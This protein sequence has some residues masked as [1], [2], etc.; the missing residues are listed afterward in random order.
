MKAKLTIAVDDPLVVSEYGLSPETVLTPDEPFFLDGPVAERV[1]VVDRDPVSGQIKPVR[2]VQEQQTY[3]VPDD[4]SQPESVAASVFG[5]VLETLELLEGADILGH[6]VKWSFDSPQLLLVPRAGT[7]DNAFYDRYSGSMQFFS[8]DGP[9]R[10]R[11]NTA[12]SRDIVTHETGHAILDGLLPAL[13]DAAT[14]QSLAL[15]EAIGDLTAIVMALQSRRIRDWLLQ[16]NGGVLEGNTPVSQLAN[17]FGWATFATKRP[18]RNANNQCTV[19]SA[20]T[21]PHDLCEVL[22][23][24]FWKAIVKLHQSAIDRA[25]ASTEASGEEALGRALGISSRRIARILFRALDYVPPAEATFA[26]YARAVLWSDGIV[27]PDDSTGYRKTLRDEFVERGI[28]GSQDEL[29]A[30]PDADEVRA[31]LNNLVESEWYAFGF[32]ERNR[33]LLRIPPRTPFRLFP[34]RDVLRRY[35][36]GGDSHSTKREV[37]FQ[38]TWQKNEENVGIPGVPP[39]RAVFQGTTLVLGGESDRRG[40]VPVLSCLTTD[41]ASEHE[42]ARNGFVLR[43]AER[44]QLETGNKWLSGNLRSQSPMVFGRVADGTLH[45]RGTGRLL[46]LAGGTND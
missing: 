32:A 36:L 9:N 17:E 20:G 26:D 34:R 39:R 11:V 18:L 19:G 28:V 44:R 15:H 46:H 25:R 40:R 38:V 31:D 14:P 22:T 37:V 4:M 24:A 6:K 30:K 45:L 10:T 13:Y 27:Y 23:G 5:I 42:E 21:E 16:R 35:Y 3:A 43:L 8:F 41:T 2:W 12:L 1:A 33:K 29:A 7:M